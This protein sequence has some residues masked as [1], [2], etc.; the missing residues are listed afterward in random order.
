MD[1]GAWWAACGPWG[2]KESDTTERAHAHTPGESSP[3]GDQNHVSCVSCVCRW[4]FTTKLPG[5][6]GKRGQNS[7]LGPALQSDPLAFTLPDRGP[8]S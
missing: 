5:Q 7:P 3:S 4:G 8:E 6:G 2:H 1:R